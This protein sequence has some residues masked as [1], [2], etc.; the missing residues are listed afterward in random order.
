MSRILCSTGA[1]I[2]RPNGRDY[3]LLK[4]LAEQLCCDGFEFMMYDTW[5]DQIDRI[6]DFVKE[7]EISTP[8]YHTEKSIGEL[9]SL[10]GEENTAKAFKN[11]EI[12]T[13]MAVKLGAEKL[14]LHLWGGMASDGQ[15]ENNYSAYKKLREIADAAGVKLMIENVVCNVKDPMTHLIELSKRYPDVLF[16]YDTKMAA[17]HNQLERL[18]E[19]DGA[20]L[21]ED[22]HIAHY[23]VNDYAGGYMDWSNLRT[24]PIG[25]GHID[26]E[27]FFEF[28]RKTGYDGTLTMESTAFDDNGVVDIDMI[29]K[30]TEY[31]RKRVS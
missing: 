12:N 21:W 23:H 8:V 4:D 20:W 2:G 11:F 18:Y 19:P 31:I 24:L 28:V 15:I 6:I 25:S 29:N 1:L 3:R 30:E 5:Y 17:F 27:R 10:G 22:G 14:V 16:T 13:E 7:N 9:I 26:F